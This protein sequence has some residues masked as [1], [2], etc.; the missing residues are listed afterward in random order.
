[1]DRRH[2]QLQHCRTDSRSRMGASTGFIDL[3]ARLYGWDGSWERRVGRFRG[4]L[5]RDKCAHLRCARLD[6]RYCC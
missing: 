6:H 4:S 3:H 5:R 2:V 1:M